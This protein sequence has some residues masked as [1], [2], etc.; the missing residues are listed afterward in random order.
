M[1]GRF[2]LTASPAKLA[3]TFHVEPPAVELAPR[4]NIAP[5]QPVAVVANNNPGRIELFQWG[6]IPFWAK[7]P[8]IGQRMINARAETLAEKPAFKAAYHRRR[9]LVLADGFYEWTK[10]KQPG[11]KKV[12]TPFY[13]QL[14]SGEPFAFAGL[15]ESWPAPDGSPLLSC[16][17]ITT[18]PNDLVTE[19]HDRMP[20]ILPAEAY[21]V[22]LD[23][24]EQNPDKLAQWLK[25]Y[26]APLMRAY[27]VTTEVNNPRNDT[28]EC[29]APLAD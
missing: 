24:A 14:A 12:K 28:P 4:Y 18:A 2:T 5:T 21:E 16:T 23:P 19:L 7:D 22:W 9:C 25:P 6:L 27:P 15:W 17:I 11:A 8:A 29:L 1:C 10:N 26:P 3:E 20:V 13:I